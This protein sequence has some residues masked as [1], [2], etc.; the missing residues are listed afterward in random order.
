MA[1]VTIRKNFKHSSK[2]RALSSNYSKINKDKIHS[3]DTCDGVYELGC[4]S[5]LAIYFGRTFK[6]CKIRIKKHLKD[7]N[8]LFYHYTITNFILALILKFCAWNSETD[9]NL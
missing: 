7:G 5:Y 6:N 8:S 2:F 1:Q 4:S 3:L 9:Q